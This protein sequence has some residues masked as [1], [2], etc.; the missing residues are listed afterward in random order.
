MSHLEKPD[1][2]S[3]LLS[4]EYGTNDSRI[5]YWLLAFCLDGIPAERCPGA[6]EEVEDAYAASV[7]AERKARA[8]GPQTPCQ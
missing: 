6:I 2:L 5:Y 4:G 3:M 1:P 7:E 8:I